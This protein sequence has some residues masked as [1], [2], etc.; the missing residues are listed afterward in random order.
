MKTY[1]FII[2]T[3]ICSISSFS[4]TKI[5]SIPISKRAN[6]DNH[7]VPLIELGNIDIESILESDTC[8]DCG[9]LIGWD[10]PKF[11]SFIEESSSEIINHD[12]QDFL[13]RRLKIIAPSAS[14]LKAKAVL[15][16]YPKIWEI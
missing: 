6:L 2:S 14:G 15:M 13:V 5:S 3:L 1:I 4:Q 7:N 16:V 11:I 12:G 8:N 9:D 10:M